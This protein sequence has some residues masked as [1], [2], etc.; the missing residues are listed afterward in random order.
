MVKKQKNRQF[1]QVQ[2]TQQ[3]ASKSQ[4]EKPHDQSQPNKKHPSPIEP[5]KIKNH[6]RK[7]EESNMEKGS[8]QDEKL[9]G[10]L[11]GRRRWRGSEG[12]RTATS[13]LLQPL[14]GLQSVSNRWSKHWKMRKHQRTLSVTAMQVVAPLLSWTSFSFEFMNRS[15]VPSWSPS[16]WCASPRTSCSA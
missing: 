16:A 11:A 7:S 2:T 4:P 9:R 14:L 12:V 3:N 8:C 15:S 10:R 6:H 13:R 1:E 5:S